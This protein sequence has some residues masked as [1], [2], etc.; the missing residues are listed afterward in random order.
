MADILQDSEKKSA[1]NPT[2]Q[3]KRVG[4]FNIT[5][6]KLTSANLD[7]KTG[8]GANMLD[9]TTSVWHELNFYEDIY[10]Q[11][12]LVILHLLIL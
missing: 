6:M 1:F 9:L 7:I 8:S 10:S 12:F 2:K 11:L 4:G 5:T 3:P